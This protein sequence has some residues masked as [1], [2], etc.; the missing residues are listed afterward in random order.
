MIDGVELKKLRLIP[1]ERG[2]LMELLR[3]DEALFQK[4]G[5]AY[6]SVVYPGV[7]KGW[8]YHK[9]QTDFIAVIKGM[10]KVVLYDRRESSPTHGQVNEYFM[11]EL[12]P[13]LIRIPPLVFH[14]MKG[15]G[16]EA[17]FFVN[18]PTEAEVDRLYAGLSDGGSVMMALDKYPF[19][20]RYAWVQDRFGVSWQLM[21]A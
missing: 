10:A 9:I 15:V 17:A 7:V 12:N 18:C 19:A 14:G 16:N 8:H 4:F 5:Q 20:A 3:S 21:C 11:G 6:V 2:F 13:T 1:D